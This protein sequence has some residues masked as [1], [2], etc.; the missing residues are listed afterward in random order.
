MKMKSL[1]I[2]VV[3]DNHYIILL[4]AL[5][6]SLEINLGINQRLDIYIIEDQINTINK[7]KLQKSINISKTVLIWK[8]MES[9]IPEDVK[10]PIDRSTYPL[11]IYMRLFIPYFIP[12]GIEKVL[13]LDVDMIAQSDISQ[14]FD[15]DLTNYVIGAVLDPGII[16][17]DNTWGGILNYKELGI[18]GNTS[19]FNTGLLLININKWKE[20]N[21]T[22][23]I[24]NCINSNKKFANYPDQYGLNVVLAN[25]WLELDPLWNHFCTINHP[26]PYIIHFV[27]RKPIYQTYDNIEEYYTIFYKYLKMTEWKC[28]KPIGEFRRYL[29]KIK[30][31]ITKLFL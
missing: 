23:K 12:E 4:A 5:I 6:K 30:N 1:N 24:I 17:F 14:L 10:L 3:C 9:I 7:A 21:I 27:R 22:D 25:Q 31:I 19:Y 16:T 28:F 15:Y 2:V 8:K 26:N 11:N 13:Y 29:H 20:Q 18:L